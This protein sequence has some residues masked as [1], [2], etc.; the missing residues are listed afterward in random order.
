MT[1]RRHYGFKE[2]QISRVPQLSVQRLPNMMWETKVKEKS[3]FPY[4]LQPTDKSLRQ[5]E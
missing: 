3:K 5:A 4:N 2:G 1:L